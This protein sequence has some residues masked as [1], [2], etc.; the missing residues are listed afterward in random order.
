ML[1]TLISGLQIVLT[2]STFILIFL[3]TVVASSSAR[4]PACPH[5][6]RWLWPCPSL[7]P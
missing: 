6:W 3:G 5:P 2:P 4:C 1:D 7:T